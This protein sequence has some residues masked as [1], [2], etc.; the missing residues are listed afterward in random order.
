M[1]GP[2]PKEAH[3]VPGHPR[4]VFLKNAVTDPRIVI[5]DYTYYDDADGHGRFQQENVLYHFGQDRLVIGRFCA[6][7][8]GAKFMMSGANH[9]MG[10]FSTYPFFT[11]GGGWERTFPAPDALPNRGDTT[12]GHDVWI[13][14]DALILPGATIGHGAIIATR[15]VVTR[16]VPPYAIVAGNPARVVRMRYPDATIAELL[17]IAWWDWTA[18]RITANLEAIL[19]ADVTALREAGNDKHRG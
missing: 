9:L 14:Y 12:V 11:F 17:D 10:G 13:G 8:H 5:G 19:G 16:D 4:V 3:P 6:I 2:D 7:A 1:T 15:A 18:D